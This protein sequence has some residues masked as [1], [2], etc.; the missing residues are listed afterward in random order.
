MGHIY[1]NAMLSLISFGVFLIS[2]TAM[3]THS[4][5]VMQAKPVTSTIQLTLMAAVS[6]STTEFTSLKGRSYRLS[7]DIPQGTTLDLSPGSNVSVTLP[8]IHNRNAVARVSSVTTHRIEFILANQVQLLDGQRLR[9]ILPAKPRNLFQI[10]FQ[11]IYSPRGQT[12]EV[13]V[14]ASDRRVHLTR[15][16]PLQVLA[17]GSVIVS[18]DHQ[19]KDALVVVHGAD[20]LVSGDLVQVVEQKDVKL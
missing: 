3:A 10:P 17:D 13:F 18:A 1:F 16:V 12:T 8:T 20:N 4:V 14:M 2:Q 15:V 19:L 5:L 9:V 11:A 6:N 7:V